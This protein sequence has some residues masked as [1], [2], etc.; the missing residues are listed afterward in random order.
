MKRN[1]WSYDHYYYYT[2]T[3][4]TTTIKVKLLPTIHDITDMPREMTCNT[5]YTLQKMIT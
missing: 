5:L 3:T 1:G 2:P 4:T